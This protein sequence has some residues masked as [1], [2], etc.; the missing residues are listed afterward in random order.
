M[1]GAQADMLWA[2]VVV[3]I[4]LLI[5]IVAL[6]WIIP[7]SVFGEAPAGMVSKSSGEDDNAAER[8]ARGA[9][10]D[11]SVNGDINRASPLTIVPQIC[12]LALL[13]WF[14]VALPAPISQCVDRASLVVVAAQQGISTQTEQADSEAHSAHPVYQLSIDVEQDEGI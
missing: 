11:L 7:S 12:L 8:G 13:L 2:V 3:A 1:A 10:V 6:L 5:S 14:G 4:A 9:S